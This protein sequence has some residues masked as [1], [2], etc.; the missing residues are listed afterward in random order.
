M[1][2]YFNNRFLIA[3]PT[4]EDPTFQK[5]VTLVCEHS[6]EGA[7]G[8]IVNRLSDHSLGELLQQL[9]HLKVDTDK[10]NIPIYTGG[11]VQ[12]ERGFVL[13]SGEGEWESSLCVAEGLYVS[14]SKDVMDAIAVGEGPKKYMITL[15]YAGWGENQLEEEM[16]DNAWI[17]IP[18]TA[19]IIFDTESDDRW[20]KAAS[21]IGVDLA[22]MSNMVGHA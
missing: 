17:S 2:N 14:T 4:L 5:T 15:G 19:D 21:T 1:T 16:I 18:A 13:H 9:G 12:P 7:L 11:P 3:M 10:F 22:T 20:S 6:E 8:L